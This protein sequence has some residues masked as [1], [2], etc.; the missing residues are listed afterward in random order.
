MA[1]IFKNLHEVVTLSSSS[2]DKI[3]YV[4]AE[5]HADGDKMLKIETGSRIFIWSPFVF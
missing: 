2:S 4:G 3:C 5:S 1:A